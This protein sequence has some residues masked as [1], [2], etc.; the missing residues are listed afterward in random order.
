[1]VDASLSSATHTMGTRS[2]ELGLVV[3]LTPKSYLHLSSLLY[4]RQDVQ[5]SQFNTPSLSQTNFNAERIVGRKPSISPPK[6]PVGS[7]SS[8]LQ[9]PTKVGSNFQRQAS[10]VRDPDGVIVKK[11]CSL[12]GQSKS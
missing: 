10:G 5:C 8:S 4:S 12:H 2:W 1:M 3:L 9:P 6:Y 7:F 11:L